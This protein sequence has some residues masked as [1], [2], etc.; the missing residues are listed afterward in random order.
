MSSTFEGMARG[1]PMLCIPVFADQHRNSY[2]LGSLGIARTLSIEQVNEKQL[3]A[4]LNEVLQNREYA[5]KAKEVGEI[6][7]DNMMHPMDEAMY[8]IEHVIK[9]NGA[10]YLKSGAV[11]LNWLQYVQLDVWILPFAILFALYILVKITIG[12][13]RV[14]L[15]RSKS[16]SA[17]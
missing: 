12:I 15:K 1:V 3:F 2:K 7:N 6:F 16:H 5:V 9:S 8:W 17:V 11:H 4:E 14:I 10:K 13:I